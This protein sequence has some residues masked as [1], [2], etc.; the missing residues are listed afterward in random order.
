MRA[1]TNAFVL[2]RARGCNVVNVGCGY[3]TIGLYVLDRHSNARWW[4]GSRG[5]GDGGEKN[6][7]AEK[8]GGG[9]TRSSGDIRDVEALRRAFDEL[10][11]VFDWSA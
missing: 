5:G 9:R 8:K 4:G 6:S 2:C 1:L 10:P 3:D 11:R 7:E